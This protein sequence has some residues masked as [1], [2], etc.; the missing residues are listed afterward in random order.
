[1]EADLDKVA[2]GE[3]EWRAVIGE[4][5]EQFAP[6]VQKAQAEMPTQKTELEKVGRECPKCGHDLVFRWGRFGK[7]ISCSNFPTCRHTE[8]W[9]EKIGAVSEVRR[10]DCGAPNANEGYS[11]AA[12]IIRSVILPL[13]SP[14]RRPARIATGCWSSLTK[15]KRS[16]PNVQ[17]L[18]YSKPLVKRLPR[19]CKGVLWVKTKPISLVD[20]GRIHDMDRIRHDNC[21]ISTKSCWIAVACFDNMF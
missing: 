3:Q 14:L 13:E 8:P 21:T 20:C 11:T 1:M 16:A 2:A 5:Y 7:F 10:R 12:P 6:Q 17:S 18:Y 9:L 19:Q 15:E 4:F